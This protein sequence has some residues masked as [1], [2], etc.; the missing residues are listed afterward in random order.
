MSRLA[1]HQDG[2]PDSGWVRLSQGTSNQAGVP[3]YDLQ[4]QASL[5]ICG[6]VKEATA[7]HVQQFAK[8][9]C[10]HAATG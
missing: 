8:H 9:H 7:L 10:Q 5:T 4:I 2:V 3:Q 1:F 6:L